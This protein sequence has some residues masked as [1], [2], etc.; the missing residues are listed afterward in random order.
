MKRKAVLIVLSVISALLAAAMAASCLL[1][2]TVYYRE[3]PNAS[4]SLVL[5]QLRGFCLDCFITYPLA[6]QSRPLRPIT[7]KTI[8]GLIWHRVSDHPS[9]QQLPD[10]SWKFTSSADKH[11]VSIQLWPVLSIIA[12]YPVIVLVR[13]FAVLG[14]PQPGHCRN[15][16]YNL[17]GNV[18]GVCPEC[19]ERIAG[20][21]IR[22]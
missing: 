10:G 4:P 13:Y 1:P 21:T 16:G 12:V 22:K 14:V 9:G 8:M 6:D 2:L 17:T 20:Q 5:V 15:C 19:G 7:E 18:S 11:E 3:K